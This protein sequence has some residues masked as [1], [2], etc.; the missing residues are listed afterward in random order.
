MIQ[1][2]L[3]T[4][5]AVYMSTHGSERPEDFEAL[6]ETYIANELGIEVEWLSY[7]VYRNGRGQD[8]RLAEGPKRGYAVV[9]DLLEISSRAHTGHP[10]VLFQRVYYQID[11]IE[12]VAL[13]LVQSDPLDLDFA[14]VHYE[15]GM[16]IE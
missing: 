7:V 10:E 6:F 2:C 16:D 15:L 13:E 1:P 4:L 5:L 11:V 8:S 9:V 14:G 3:E 12:P